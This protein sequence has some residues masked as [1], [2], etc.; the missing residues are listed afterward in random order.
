M[1]LAR[2]LLRQKKQELLA[3]VAEIRKD[4]RELDAAL[5]LLEGGGKDAASSEG[6]FFSPTVTAGPSPINAA[7]LEAIKN[8]NGTPEAIYLFIRDH[9]QIDTTKNSVSTRLSKMKNDG[10]IDNDG[11]GWTVV[12]K[13]EGPGASTSEPSK[14]EMGP[15][16]GR[17]TV[18][19][20]TPPEGSIPS[21]ST[22]SRPFG[23]IFGESREMR[24]ADDEI[25]F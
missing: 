11:Q 20:A 15:A 6:K 16:T 3:Q 13:A 10:L 7:I 2:D 5:E 1:S 4:I 9:L 18:F 24:D 22:A 14:P 25:P 21:G 8:G 17:G 23:P 12:Q 19:P